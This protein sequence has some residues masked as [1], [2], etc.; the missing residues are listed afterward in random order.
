MPG[1]N[2]LAE[3][4]HHAVA[5]LLEQCLAQSGAVYGFENL[6][7][8]GADI[9]EIYAKV[10]VYKKARTYEI[11]PY[12]SQSYAQPWVEWSWTPASGLQISVRAPSVL[13]IGMLL[14]WKARGN[15]FEKEVVGDCF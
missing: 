9:V 12:R 13:Y 8:E 5:I 7:T 14:D 10:S 15:H 2:L 3:D 1:L 11:L 6:C 4:G